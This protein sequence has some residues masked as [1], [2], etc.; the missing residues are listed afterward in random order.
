MLINNF[1]QVYLRSLLCRNKT[2]ITHLWVISLAGF[3]EKR[4]N[5]F[6]T[7]SRIAGNAYGQPQIEANRPPTERRLPFQMAIFQ[8]G[9]RK[10]AAGLE[11]GSGQRILA[12]GG[13]KKEALAKAKNS[14]LSRRSG[15]TSF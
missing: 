2:K 15:T 14:S 3:T 11:S 7:E 9:A 1:C 4:F 13:G 8:G 6:P 12:A 5:L 10:G